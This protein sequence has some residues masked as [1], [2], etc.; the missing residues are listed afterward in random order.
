MDQIVKD[1][2]GQDKELIIY[3]EGTGDFWVIEWYFSNTMWW[4]MQA[5]LLQREE[6]REIRTYGKSL[7]ARM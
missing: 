3:K 7:N 5:D 4:H 2:K 6:S 1:L